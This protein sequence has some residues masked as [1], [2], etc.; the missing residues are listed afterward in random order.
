MQELSASK[1]MVA[2]ELVGP[3]AG[4]TIIKGK[5]YHFKDG[6]I[7]APIQD[8]DKLAKVLATYGAFRKEIA[9][10]KNKSAK[11]AV[12]LLSEKDKSV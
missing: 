3:E 4:K 2:F 10:E 11:K 5:R 1:N 12:K 8:A 6:V 9:A 7:L